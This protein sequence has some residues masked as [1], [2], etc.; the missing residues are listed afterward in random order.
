MTVQEQPALPALPDRARH[1]RWGYYGVRV[2]LAVLMLAIAALLPAL[3]S[4]GDRFH[5]REGDIM[6]ARVVA[7]Y[8]FRV[9]KDEATLRR[10]QAQAAAAVPPVFV[11]DTRVSAEMLARLATFQ[12]KAF[13]VVLSPGIKPGS[14][15]TACGRWACR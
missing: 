9:E 3:R 15:W 13:G 1:V 4:G 14:A 6:R 7:P 5:Y 12:E 2:L 10:E 11:V 8:D